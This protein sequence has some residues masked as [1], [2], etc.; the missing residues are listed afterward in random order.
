MEPRNHA[1]NHEVLVRHDRNGSDIE[2]PVADVEDS[3]GIHD[4]SVN[5]KATTT[6]NTEYPREFCEEQK[7]KQN[8][9][10]RLR[11]GGL[12]DSFT[13]DMNTTGLSPCCCGC[14]SP[15]ESSPSTFQLAT[16]WLGKVVPEGHRIITGATVV[17]VALFLGVFIP[18]ETE[19]NKRSDRAVSVFGYLVFMAGL[20]IT[21]RH[22]KHINWK[23]VVV[24]ILVQFIMGFFVL[25]TTLGKTIFKFIS[26]ALTTLLEYAYQGV[27]FLTD[28]SVLKLGWFLVNSLSV[29]VFFVALVQMAYYVGFIQWGVQKLAYFFGWAFSLSGTE[30]LAAGVTPFLGMGEA[31]IIIKGFIPELTQAEI[32][33]V[34]TAGFATISGS[35]MV[36]Y[37][38]LGASGQAVISSCLMSIPI[39]IA[40]SKM[41]VPETEEPLTLGH[42]SILNNEPEDGNS[43]TNILHAMANGAWTG[44]K[45]AGMVAANLIVIIAIVALCNGILQWCFKYIGAPHVTISQI[46]GYIFYPVAFLMGVP[47][48]ELYLV[49]QLIGLKT[50]QNEF[51]AFAALT[52]QSKFQ[53]ISPRGTIIATYAICGFANI[54]SIGIQLGIYGQLSPKRRGDFARE[55]LSACICGALATF[56]SASLAGM[57]F[58]G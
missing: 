19:Y 32:H 36:V 37:I 27:V 35:L 10:E 24:G 43:E 55:A 56:M 2:I 13:T 58:T 46:F 21:S 20:Y 54:G 23:P 45:V 39:S 53:A 16:A 18:G 47:R 44:L 40:I 4:G 31:A 30:A 49:G 50:I 34:M 5:E 7:P 52:E 28:S 38:G 57:I 26:D 1:H 15:F 17:I 41:R 22:R 42:V 29:F 25:R 3:S 48:N 9:K 14:S 12:L 6:V 11:H 51:V 33:Q 8:H